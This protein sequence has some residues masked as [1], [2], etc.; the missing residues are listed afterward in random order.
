[1][2]HSRMQFLVAIAAVVAGMLGLQAKTV[3]WYHF[4]EGANGTKPAN[5]QP[6]FVNAADPGSLDGH[7]KGQ[8]VLVE[9]PGV[10]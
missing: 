10:S 5:A 9:N 8:E 7:S 1:M 3:A 2:K 6:V 4:N